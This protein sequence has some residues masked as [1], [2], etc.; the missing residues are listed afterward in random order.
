M[1]VFAQCGSRKG[2]VAG[3]IVTEALRLG[4]VQGAVL[5]PANESPADLDALIAECRKAKQ[6]ID[7]LIDP[8][9]YVSTLSGVRDTHL[10]E[11]GWFPKKTLK[12]S[13]FTLRETQRIVRAAL[14]WQYQRA[15]TTIVAPSIPIGAFD[16]DPFAQI[17]Y[18]MAEEAC[19]YHA[20][21]GRAATG[22]AKPLLISLVV[23]EDALQ[24]TQPVRE[25]VDRL[26]GLDP[27]PAGVYLVVERL[28]PGYTPLFEERALT[29]L[30][31]CCHVLGN[32]D[33]WRVVLGY[34]DMIGIVAQAAG[35]TTSAC[36]WHQKLRYFHQQHW[37]ESKGGAT[38]R[39]RYTA[40]P[41][42]DSLL[43]TP[44]LTALDL[45][46]LYPH[47]RSGT[48]F[49]VTCPQEDNWMPTTS[50]HHHWE[51]LSNRASTIANVTGAAQRLDAIEDMLSKA[52]HLGHLIEKK[53]IPF[54]K[55]KPTGHIEGWIR[56]LRTHR[57]AIKL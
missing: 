31:H 47:V 41:L 3:S 49:D 19:A 22:Q 21:K 52:L 32:L 56:A 26:R 7:V 17:A 51:S 14:D 5:S 40:S 57:D 20:E 6:D 55:R 8:Q 44:E 53:G 15:V 34:T 16:R 43:I 36:G 2:G 46:G 1:T 42:F 12:A 30:L 18:M 37:M 29:N 45:D 35:A 23:R 11:H 9:L 54:E 24:A 4:L 13:S 27:C 38:P 28:N 25:F 39:R 10:P 48:R 33:A 50:T